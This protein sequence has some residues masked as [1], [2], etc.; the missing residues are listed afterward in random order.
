ME[1]LAYRTTGTGTA[2]VLQT[3]GRE[4]T[5]DYL[6]LET[7][8]ILMRQI[9]GDSISALHDQSSAGNSIRIAVTDNPG[10]AAHLRQPRLNTSA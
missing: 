10:P 1:E 2:L 3:E 5:F 8:E 7:K 9:V 4:S 6:V